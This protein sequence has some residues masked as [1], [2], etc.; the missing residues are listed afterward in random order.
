[1]SERTPKK[2]FPTDRP[3]D[4]RRR[5]AKVVHDDRG[6]ASV[7]WEEAP[8]DHKRD[9]LELLEDAAPA[10]G[11]Q[12][13]DP[14]ARDN[15]PKPKRDASRAPRTDLRKLSEWIKMMR[16]LEARKRNGNPDDEGKGEG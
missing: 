15:V 14:Y 8:P 6:N 5:V 2:R 13:G 11:G 1:M 10:R 16:E 3:P 7:E 9:V 4:E 12:G